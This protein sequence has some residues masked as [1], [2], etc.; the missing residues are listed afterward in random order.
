MDYD[1]AFPTE[2][3]AIAEDAREGTYRP[4]HVFSYEQESYDFSYSFELEDLESYSYEFIDSTSEEGATSYSHA[5]SYSTS[6]SYQ[7][8][9]EVGN[10]P[11]PPGAVQSVTS[12]DVSVYAVIP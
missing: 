10:E 2:E 5:Y 7:F 9:E 1:W 11:P 8:R 3:P 6:Y 4:A 12:M